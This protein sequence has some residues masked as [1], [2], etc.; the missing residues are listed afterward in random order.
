MGSSLVW[1]LNPKTHSLPDKLKYKLRIDGERVF[2]SSDIPYLQGL[3]DCDVDGAEILIK[4]I[5]K[6]GEINLKLE[7]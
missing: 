7:W 1:Y 3:A 2:D 5:K 4:L 6:Y